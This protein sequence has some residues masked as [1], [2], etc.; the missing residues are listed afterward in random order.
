MSLHPQARAALSVQPRVPLTTGN[1][2]ASR[3][4]MVDASVTE[5]GPGPQVRSV[6]DLDVDGVPC[7]LYRPGDAAAGA[8][9]YAHGGG[10][11]LGTLDTH[12]T[13]CRELAARSGLP[14]LSVAYRLAPEH[15]YPAAVE[16]VETAAAWLRGADAEAHGVRTTALAIVGDSAGAH[17]AAAVARRARDAGRPYRGQVLIY[18]V[19]DPAQEYVDRDE[20]GLTAGEMRFFWDAYAPAGV[21]R[22]HPD[23]A[24]L[25]AELA[26]LPPALVLTAEYDVLREEGERYADA[27]AAAGVPT[28]ATRYLGA[29]HGFARKLALFDAARA[30]A[31][32]VAVALTDMLRPA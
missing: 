6:V 26:G 25:T 5:A 17:V 4:S 18:P 12:D 32:Q 11:A 19:V 14:V 29:T 21:D 24:L 9:V 7:R 31:G 30:A 1:L 3:Q 8:V 22:S 16:D 13:L 20:Y 27:L 10:W 15:P 2:A 28:V 23:L